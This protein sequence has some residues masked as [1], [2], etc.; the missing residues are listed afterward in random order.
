MCLSERNLNVRF[1]ISTHHGFHFDVIKLEELAGLRL[2]PAVSIFI[3]EPSLPAGPTQPQQ[4][5]PHHQWCSVMSTRRYS[6]FSLNKR[7]IKHLNIWI[8]LRLCLSK[9]IKLY[10]YI[11]RYIYFRSI[12][13]ALK[14]NLQQDTRSQKI[15]RCFNLRRF[16]WFWIEF[17]YG[18]SSSVLDQLVSD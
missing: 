7:I 13:L 6:A 3:V 1:L 18:V 4:P 2:A 5:R 16:Q 12:P 10:V 15:D 8:K 9:E 11:F 14:T 17:K